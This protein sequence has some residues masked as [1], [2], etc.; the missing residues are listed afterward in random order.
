MN[1]EVVNI[2]KMHVELRAVLEFNSSDLGIDDSP[3]VE[4]MHATINIFMVPFSDPPI[5]TKAIYLTLTFNGQVGTVLEVNEGSR[6]WL[7]E[8][9]IVDRSLNNTINLEG[10]VI[11]IDHIDRHGLN[12]VIRGQ[13]DQTISRV[14]LIEA[15]L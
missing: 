6:L 12:Y 11:K 10:H 8:V 13:M 7:R 2:L 14:S 9:F 3:K 1:P 5:I 15:A 4:K